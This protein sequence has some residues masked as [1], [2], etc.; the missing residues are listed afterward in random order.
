MAGRSKGIVDRAQLLRAGITPKEINGRLRSGQLIKE[1]RGVYRV[2][3]AAPS[4]DATYMAAV[5]AAGPGAL[6]CGR[7]AAWVLGLTKGKAPPAEVLTRCN[8]RIP[9]VRVH[10][11]KRIHPR[12]RGLWRGIPLTSAARTVVDLAVELDAEELA[13]AFHEAGIRHHTTP[14]QVEAV[15]V[16]QSNAPGAAKLRAVTSGDEQVVLSRLEAK[17]V[18]DLR[19]A[20]QL[21]PDTNQ[22]A[23]TKRV[24]CHW[25]QLGLIIELD[26]YR[27]HRSRHAWEQDRRREREARKRG[28]EL[29]RFT[30]DD[31]FLRGPETIREV[32][33][34]I[35]R[36]LRL[37][38][39]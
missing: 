17:F 34:L 20:G 21:L 31:V 7:A 25:P 36:R 2:G 15:L 35:A 30:H 14:D 32:G 22:P 1:H 24:D 19:E 9:G 39:A 26:S 3:H 37:R 16:R 33:R 23:G 5:R 10:R 8:R 13:R 11:T 27:Y 12:E 6:L 28:E 18:A 4:P 29:H 38:A